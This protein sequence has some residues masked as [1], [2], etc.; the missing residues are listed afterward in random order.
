MTFY[1]LMSGAG[2]VGGAYSHDW[3]MAW[4]S[5]AILGIV[6]YVLSI[7]SKNDI[8]PAG[9]NWQAGLMGIVVALVLICFLGW[10]KLALL[11]GFLVM[12]IIGWLVGG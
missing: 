10:A 7:L 9:F 8:I 5:L 11:I 1:N 4:A 3:I 2:F 6:V 12:I